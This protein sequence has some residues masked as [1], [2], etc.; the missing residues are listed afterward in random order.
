MFAGSTKTGENDNWGG[1]TALTTAI[2]AF[3][4]FPFANPASLDAAVLASI[5]PGDNSVRIS[6]TGSGTGTVIAELYDATPSASFLATTPRLVTVSVLKHLG[7]VLTAGFVVGGTGAKTVLIRVVGPTLGAAP[8]NVPGTVADPQLTLFAGQTVIGSNDN[9]G[10]TAALA[11]A[12]TQVGAF[13]LPAASRDAAL[14]ATLQ[15]GG[16]TVQARGATG[17]TGMAIVEIYEVP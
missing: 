4:G 17:T 10:G 8:F 15:P 9:W 16:Y 1:T 5:P 2:A 14:L 6:A 13:P 3:T 7:T 12:F 11:A